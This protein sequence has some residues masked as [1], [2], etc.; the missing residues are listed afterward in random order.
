MQG[1]R[2]I[3]NEID[4]LWPVTIRLHISFPE[5]LLPLQTHRLKLLYEAATSVIR[6]PEPGKRRTLFFDLQSTPREK[7]LRDNTAEALIQGSCKCK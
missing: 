7:F 6:E 2:G 5:K 1:L 4:W 3:F